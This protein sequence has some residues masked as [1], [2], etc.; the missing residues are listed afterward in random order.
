MSNTEKHDSLIEE[1]RSINDEIELVDAEIRAN[2]GQTK[3]EL[4][5]DLWAERL[6]LRCVAGGILGILLCALV[7]LYMN[8][9]PEDISKVASHLLTVL[10]GAF[11]GYFAGKKSG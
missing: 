6:R 4:D 5:H 8:G 7:G 9:T 1:Y 3:A 10:G 2:Q 11:G